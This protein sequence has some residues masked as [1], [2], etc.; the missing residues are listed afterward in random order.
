MVNESERLTYLN[1]DPS[2]ETTGTTSLVTSNDDE[3]IPQTSMKLQRY[4]N[5]L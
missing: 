1:E 2:I 4:T 5:I 3:L